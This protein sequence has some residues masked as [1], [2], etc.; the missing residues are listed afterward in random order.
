[1]RDVVLGEAADG[2]DFGFD[3]L[4]ICSVYDE[5]EGGEQAEGDDVETE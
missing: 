1:M 3:R 2:I 4:E 5:H